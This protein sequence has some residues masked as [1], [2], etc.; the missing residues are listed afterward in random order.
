MALATFASG[1]SFAWQV[2]PVADGY[3]VVA[4][5]PAQL[6]APP[7]AATGVTTATNFEV[8]G[9]PGAARTFRWAP[10]AATDGPLVALSTADASA[11]IPDPAAVGLPLPAGGGYT[12]TVVGTAADGANALARPEAAEFLN[13][14]AFLDRGGGGP[15]FTQDGA[16]VV[17]TGRTFTLAP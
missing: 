3:A 12:W 7:D 1:N 16:Y 4:P 15:G 5:A 9:G 2:G 10:D 17:R 8:V 13:T 14:A 11:T 6:L